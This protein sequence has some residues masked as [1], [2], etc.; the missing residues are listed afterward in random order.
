MSLHFFKLTEVNDHEGETWHFW[1]QAEGNADALHAIRTAISEFDD[2]AAQ[3]REEECPY[4]LGGML[5]PESEVDI[6]VRHGEDG[7]MAQH[8]KLTGVL[9]LP[10]P[11]GPD[12]LDELYKG[13]VRDLF[14]KAEAAAR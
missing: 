1:L 12:H 2:A 8:T 4:F 5:V 13:G 7:Y 14:A 10:S 6:V 11:F 9:T 3:Q